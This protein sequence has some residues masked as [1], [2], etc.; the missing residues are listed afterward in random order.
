MYKRKLFI[1]FFLVFGVLTFL[2]L[3]QDVQM[4]H[5]TSLVAGPRGFSFITKEHKVCQVE[6]SGKYQI[7]EQMNG[8]VSICQED[9]TLCAIL[10]DGSF[11]AFPSIDV[12][13][14]IESISYSRNVGIGAMYTINNIQQYEKI[15]NAVFFRSN[16]PGD[17]IFVHADGSVTLIGF[18]TSNEMEHLN[19]ENTWKGIIQLA[20]TSNE[21]VG[22]S[23]DGSIVY[24]EHSQY[25]EI[26][27]KWT[28]IA[29]IYGGGNHIFALTKTGAVKSTGKDVWGE[30]NV[31]LWENIISLSPA[32]TYTVGLRS[33]G[34][35]VATGAN[36]YGQ[37]DVQNW[38][39]IIAISAYETYTLGIDNEGHIWI[40]GKTD[41]SVNLKKCSDI[42][43]TQY[44]LLNPV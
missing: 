39:N 33:D 10:D 4:N 6:F 43:L 34:T 31:A 24:T 38:H 12:E 25:C 40:A 42:V 14:Y 1:L 8:A 13:E 3:T 30:S 16:Y 22:L 41:E 32:R 23:Q 15:R 29:A 20:K 19:I 35:V 7:I 5:C 21:L 2:P 26:Y 11:V 17:G 36:S 44:N 9:D 27:K 28:D 18:I 37:C